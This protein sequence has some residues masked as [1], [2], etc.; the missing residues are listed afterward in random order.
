[1][2]VIAAQAGFGAYWPYS[3]TARKTT[4][5]LEVNQ[6]ENAMLGHTGKRLG[7][8]RVV[9][10]DTGGTLISGGPV[11]GGWLSPSDQRRRVFAPPELVRT[12]C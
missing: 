6:D 7:R 4:D 8:V 2:R 5:E 3:E 10:A 11:P 12:S 1:M 9:L